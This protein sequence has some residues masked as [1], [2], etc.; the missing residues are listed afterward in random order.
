M[1]RLNRTARKKLHLIKAEGLDPDID[2]LRTFAEFD[3]ALTAPLHGFRDARDYY[4]RCSSA[5]LLKQ[6]ETPVL[7]LHAR[8]DPFMLPETV[9]T[10][11][12][13]SPAVTLEVSD[14]G[15]HCG[16]VSGRWPWRAEFWSEQRILERLAEFFPVR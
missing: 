15:G 6:I 8:D 11:D 1:R 2:S 9:P 5:P 14:A 12:M 10:A 16:F 4:A 7:I 13:L 3:N